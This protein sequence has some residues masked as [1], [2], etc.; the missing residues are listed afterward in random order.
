MRIH[1]PDLPNP[2]MTIICLHNPLNLGPHGWGHNWVGGSMANTRIS[3]NDPAFWFHH[4][5]VDRIWATWQIA[6]PGKIAALTGNEALLD[7]WENE[8]TVGNIDD[9]SNLKGDSYEYVQ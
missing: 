8:F 6:N 1:S 4:A 5:Q 7:P 9:I 2:H 3:P